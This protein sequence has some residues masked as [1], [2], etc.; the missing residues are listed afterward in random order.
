MSTSLTDPSFKALL[1]VPSASV[2]EFFSGQAHSLSNKTLP[3]LI[4]YCARASLSYVESDGHRATLLFYTMKEFCDDFWYPSN[5][6]PGTR[7]KPKIID[8]NDLENVL[9]AA[10]EQGDYNFFN[11]ACMMHGD[12]LPPT[13]FT[14]AENWLKDPNTDSD[15]D[16]FLKEGCVLNQRVYTWKKETS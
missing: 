9:R 12:V 15:F 10:L 6:R 11:D 4:G 7:S 3:Y 13:F 2:Y 14:W 1:L 16:D 8:G 5:E